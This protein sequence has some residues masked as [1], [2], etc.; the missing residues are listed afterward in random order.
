MQNTTHRID[1]QGPIEKHMELLI[2]SVFYNKMGKTMEK[3]IYLK[4]PNIHQ[5]RNE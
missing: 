5:Q 3:N 1:E 2:F 4:Q